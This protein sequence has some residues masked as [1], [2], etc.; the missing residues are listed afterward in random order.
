MLELQQQGTMLWK[1]E[2][3]QQGTMVTVGAPT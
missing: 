1:K 2:K 3:K